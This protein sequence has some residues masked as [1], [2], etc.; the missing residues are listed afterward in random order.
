M[1]YLKQF[2]FIFI[3][4]IGK[5]L[6]A[7]EDILIL[8]K[9]LKT[10]NKSDFKDAWNAIKDGDYF[11]Q[12]GWAYYSSAIEYYAKANQY[13]PNIAALNYK[14]GVCYL[15]SIEKNT[16][17]KY[18][19]KAYELNSKVSYDINFQIGRA[20]HLNL[21]FNKAISFYKKFLIDIETYKLDYTPEE[22]NN[23]IK[24][25]ETGL[26]LID[27]PVNAV[28]E[29][30]GSAV[31]S[32][33]PEY[34]P[35][36]TADESVLIFT[37]R[38]K[39]STGNYKD[40]IDNLYLE[41]VYL[42]FREKS[43][44]RKPVNLG[45]PINTNDHDAA[46]GLSSDGQMMYLYKGN[47]NGGDIFVCRL[48]GDIWTTP[49]PLN[50]NINTDFHEASVSLAPNGRELFLIS[51]RQDKT[52]GEHDI[53]VSKK[54][55]TGKWGE[56]QNLGSVINTKYDEVSAFIHP[57]GK[58]LYF[59][60]KGHNTM[61]G[62]DIFRSIRDEAGKWSTP[63]NIGY[64]INTPD[65]DIYFVVSA[66]GA[67]GYFSSVKP[68]GYGDKDIYQITFFEDIPDSLKTDTSLIAEIPKKEL[69]TRGL[70]IIKG[71]T[72]DGITLEPIEA[73]I[74]IVDNDKGEIVATYISNSK[75][76]V[77]LIPLPSGKNYGIAIEADG[78]LFH[79]DNINI[80][81]DDEFEEIV[82]QIKLINI[83]EGSKIILRN[84]FFDSDQSNL[85][86]QS[87]V[88]LNRL[89]DLLQ[90]YST[91]KIEISGHTDNVGSYA[92]NQEL[93]KQRAQAVVD[94]LI[95]NGIDAS[96]LTAKGYSYDHPIAPND[97]EEN[98]QL[99]RRVEFKITA[100]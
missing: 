71:K 44:W 86:N 23:Y 67:H 70:T 22:I 63:E 47:T 81:P 66:S 26:K 30:I 12:K 55:S 21:E 50:Q 45:S 77:Y 10:D 68:K 56:V 91:L 100:K 88:E 87:Q 14:L 29:N 41:D 79:S 84:L 57:D 49:Q 48:K 33:Y 89:V 51:N 3:L 76:G 34:G 11:Y 75:T 8:K 93:S 69:K 42:S 13:N 90:N 54:D 73:R 99:N 72:I 28:L 19:K 1:N 17:I 94:Y 83:K 43:E 65:D 64:P 78:Y 32:Q 40:E 82:N 18:L 36:I 98:R 58:T 6:F 96:R 61:G 80:S 52:L 31:N 9:D 24:Q 92:H 16:A 37:S 59:S 35:L 85:R 15:F 53:F 97:T 38:R 27:R 60:S 4:I 5:Q 62:F 2:I 39:G 74:E 7:Q 20:Y 25:C 95:E 46:V